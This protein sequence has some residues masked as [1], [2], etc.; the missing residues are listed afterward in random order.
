MGPEARMYTGM[1]GGIL[2]PLGC[3]IFAWTS[4]PS[5]HWIVPTIGAGILFAG[6]FLLYLTVFSKLSIWP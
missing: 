2:F 5:I 4:F 3:W 6:M 1:A